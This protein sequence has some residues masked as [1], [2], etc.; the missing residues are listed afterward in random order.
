MS[1]TLPPTEMTPTDLES[2]R[3]AR[4]LL[5]SQSFIGQLTQYIGM[6]VEAAMA[7]LPEKW[8][9]VVQKSSRTALDKALA[10]AIK[11]LGK[12]G[13]P[14][15]R[16]ETWHRVAAGISGAAGGAGGAAALALELPVSTVIMLRSIADI[17]RSEG[18]D[19]TQPD[20]KL[21]CLEVFALG[22][23][24]ASPDN[25]DQA[26]ETGYWG[27]RFGLSTA[28]RNA[29]NELA[30]S[31]TGRGGA[32]VTRF[33]AAVAAR[34]NVVVTEK[35]AAQAVPIIGAA[36]GALINTLFIGHFQDV[37][38]GHFI[39]RRLERTY[40]SDLVRREYEKLRV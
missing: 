15:P 5:E 7:S 37:A 34:F 6:P 12:R 26:K 17:A 23:S 38:R 18:E 31:A 16:S 1:E 39:V 33:V 19:L 4:Q 2:L 10:A 27:L 20:A 25:R 8:L 30:R 40:G 32:A 21:A 28:L 11:T 35:V 36:G 22:G 14:S 24:L 3:R 9:G 29:T 13:T